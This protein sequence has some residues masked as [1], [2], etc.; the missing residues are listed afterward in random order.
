MQSYGRGFIV[1]YILWYSQEKNLADSSLH[2]P[3][4]AGFGMANVTELSERKPWQLNQADS[5]LHY[6]PFGMTIMSKYGR[7]E[8]AEAAAPPLLLP[9]FYAS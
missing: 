8:E 5:S 7:E 4:H 3:A 9:P 2:Y 1:L 6:V